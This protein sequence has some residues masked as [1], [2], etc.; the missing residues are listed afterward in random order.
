MNDMWGNPI[1][2]GMPNVGMNN[3]MNVFPRF[4]ATS[5]GNNIL[6]HYELIK[7]KNEESARQFRMG[8]NSD[9]LLLDERDPILYHVQTDGAGYVDVMS[10]DLIP[11]MKVQPVDINQL[12]QR[13][14]QLEDTL[15]A[16]QSN[17]QPSKQKKQRNTTA[18]ATTDVTTIANSGNQTINESI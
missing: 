11:R 4:N 7:V 13:I 5:F 1:N 15:N 16:R 9:V 8:P 12:A 18:T 10:Y 6:P 2:G 17:S 3:G 14:A